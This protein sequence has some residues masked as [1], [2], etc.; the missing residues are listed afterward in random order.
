MGGSL[1]KKH[2]KNDINSLSINSRNGLSKGKE[3]E[4][5]NKQNIYKELI[6]LVIMIK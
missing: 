1:L 5:K 6:T 4:K 3:S 2:K